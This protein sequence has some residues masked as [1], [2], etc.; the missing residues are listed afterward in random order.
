MANKARQICLNIRT[1]SAVF[2]VPQTYGN[3]HGEAQLKMI[4]HTVDGTNPA[5]PK[6]WL[7]PYK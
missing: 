7:K 2:T 4:K 5:P 6:G 3:T 1:L